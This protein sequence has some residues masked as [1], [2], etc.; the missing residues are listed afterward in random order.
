ME[1]NVGERHRQ[2]SHLRRIWNSLF[3]CVP[4]TLEVKMLSTLAQGGACCSFKSLELFRTKKRCGWLMLFWNPRENVFG[5]C[6]ALLGASSCGKS[7]RLSM[8]HIPHVCISWG[9]T[10]GGSHI[11][12]HSFHVGLILSC[13]FIAPCFLL[14]CQGFIYCGVCS[15]NMRKSL[16]S[17]GTCSRIRQQRSRRTVRSPAL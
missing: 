16:E 1:V 17:N 12:A 5:P 9:Y 14:P 13:W 6:M 10:G 11:G 4:H 8:F 7:A 2:Q 3:R 15:R